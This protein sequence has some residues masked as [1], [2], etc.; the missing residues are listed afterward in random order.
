MLILIKK[1]DK[2]LKFLRRE[3]LYEMKKGVVFEIIKKS[4]CEWFCPLF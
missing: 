2:K 1:V 4:M 3:E